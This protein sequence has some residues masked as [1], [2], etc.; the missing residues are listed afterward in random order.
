MSSL[1]GTDF[2]RPGG[3]PAPSKPG[4]G[5]TAVADPV[6]RSATV[7]GRAP[8]MMALLFAL[9]SLGGAASLASGQE[10]APALRFASPDG[11]RAMESTERLSV[12]LPPGTE[13]RTVR[14]VFS[15]DGRRVLRGRSR[16]V[17][18]FL[19]LRERRSG[20]RH[21]GR[22]RDGRRHPPR[23]TGAYPHAHVHPFPHVRG[24]RDGAG[25]RDRPVT[26]V[27]SPSSRRSASSCSRT[28]LRRTSPTS[29]RP[30]SGA[31]STWRSPSTSAAAWR[32]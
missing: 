15:V 28:G 20:S 25:G 27:T 23:R 12:V 2:L 24:T 32:R 8:G 10:A 31:S 7:P 16:P 18:V 29:R 4:R 3:D 9:T 21:P 6:V 19:G 22:R 17:R 30:P 26:G 1:T 11:S 5:L 14:V 13:E